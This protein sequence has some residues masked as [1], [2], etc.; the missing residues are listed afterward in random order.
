MRK[1]LQFRGTSISYLLKGHSEPTIVLLHGN[2][3]SSYSFQAQF[4]DNALDAFTLLSIDLPGHGDSP[5]AADAQITYNLFFFRDLIIY[6]LQFL[7][8]NNFIFAGHSLG[9]HV[10]IE[11]LP[12]TN[13]CRGLFLWGAPPVKLPLKTETIFK[14]SLS[15]GMLFNADLSPDEINQLSTLLTSKRHKHKLSGM[16]ANTDPA[17]RKFFPISLVNGQVSDEYF[18]LKESKLPVAIIHGDKDDLINAGY[19]T[20]LDLPT[21][22]QNRIIIIKKAFHIPHLEQPKIFNPLLKQFA[23]DYL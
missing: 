13:G 2:S 23:T 15:A 16:I 7:G 18:L 1:I 22:W 21:L 17:F 10:A 6:T 9:G 19:Y 14:P 11:C 4:E 5:P 8:I 12:Y 20:Y 3:L